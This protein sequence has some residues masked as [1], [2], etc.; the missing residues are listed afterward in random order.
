[1][2]SLKRKFTDVT[3]FVAEIEIGSERYTP[4]LF[5]T[6]SHKQLIRRQSPLTY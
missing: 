5:G 2:Q 3:I 1:K 4:Q 6:W